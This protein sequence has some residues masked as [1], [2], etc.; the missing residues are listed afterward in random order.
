MVSLPHEDQGHVTPTGE[1]ATTSRVGEP[2]LAVLH[3]EFS[4]NW[5]GQEFRVLEQMDWLRRAG[6]RVALA[7]RAG[8]DMARRAAV[9]GHVC[10]QLVL[11]AVYNPVNLARAYALV[12]RE[13]FDIVDCHG[14]REAIAFTAARG[15]SRLV[16][17]QHVTGKIKAGLRHRL[18][19]GAACDHVVATAAHIKD[20]LLAIGIP[21]R[22]VS[23][24]GEWASEA[25]FQLDDKPRHRAEVRAEF[26]VAAEQ[27]LIV[28]VGMLRHDK[29]QEYV[30][31]AV[32]LLRER[33]LDVVLLVVG[34][35]TA[36]AACEADCHEA[37][38]RRRAAAHGLD[39]RVIF[40]GY[41]S[42]VV[43]LVQAADA[44]VV[45]SVAV[46][47][48]SRTVP[49]A[50]ASQV[51][52][53]ATNAGGLSELVADG[54]TGRVVPPRDGAAIA[55]AVAALLSDRS[56]T[57]AMVAAARRLAEDSLSLETKMRDTLA[58]YFRLRD[59]RDGTIEG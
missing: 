40:T 58:L 20:E 15:R 30:I 6:H 25:F 19:W 34:S 5:G 49:Q 52:V 1:Q 7:C 33:G 43:R 21:D 10:H 2:R 42:D 23:V 47:G 46:E 18:V 31:D 3:A 53:V 27:A 4:A 29:G 45:A 50:F 11:R 32:A 17:S 37:L 12:V 38:L 26:G 14:L 22:H 8:S 59:A 56:A 48:Q 39:E 13:G 41:R 36:Q 51:P 57:A 9:A 28:N 16:R 55:M 35:S 24:I 44:Q 54:I